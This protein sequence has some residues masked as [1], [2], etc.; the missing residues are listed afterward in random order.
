VL[1]TSGG[2]FEASGEYRDQQ[3]N[4]IESWSGDGSVSALAGGVIDK[5]GFVQSYVSV[6][7]SAPY[8]RNGNAATFSIFPGVETLTTQMTDDFEIPGFTYSSGSGTATAT[9]QFTT[10]TATHTPTSTTV[11]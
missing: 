6:T 7:A 10:F 5:T 4:L 2:T 8:I 11:R 9:G 3:G 1:P